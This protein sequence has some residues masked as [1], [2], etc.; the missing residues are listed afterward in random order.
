MKTILKF[1]KQIAIV[2]TAVVMF[3]VTSCHKEGTGG[4]S[5][6]TGQVKHHEKPIPN[7]VVYIK[8]DTENFPGT[9]TSNYDGSTTADG[10]GNYTFDGLR[11][12]DYYLYGVGYDTDISEIVSGGV[13]VKLKR[14][15]E[16]NVNVPVTE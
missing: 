3:T 10:N 4:K 1:S 13:G 6:I 9:S 7:C 12:G 8:Y 15:K 11:K 14:N 16:T 2:L 5:S